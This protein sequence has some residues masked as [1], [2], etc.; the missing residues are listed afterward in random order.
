MPQEIRHTVGHAQHWDGPEAV[1]DQHDARQLLHVQHPKDIGDERVQTDLL[2]EQ[3]CMLAE[4]GER[5]REHAMPDRTQWLSDP[6]PAP[7]AVEEPMDQNEY[8]TN[9]RLDP[10]CGT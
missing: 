9:A 5:G 1:P 10:G 2:I 4:S 8:V 3:V 7:A 6:P